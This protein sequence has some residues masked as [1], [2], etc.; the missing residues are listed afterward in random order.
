MRHI[1]KGKEPKVLTDHKKDGNTLYKGLNITDIQQ[2]LLQEQRGLCA[3]CMCRIDAIAGRT[4]NMQVE[5]VKCRTNY[6]DDELEYVNMLG[7]CFGGEKNNMMQPHCDKSKDKGEVHYE[8]R[9][10][11]PLNI[12]VESM[13]TFL[14][15]GTVV[16]VNNDKDVIMDIKALN[17]NEMYTRI[18]R[19]KISQSIKE[20]YKIVCKSENKAKVIQFLEK[21]LIKWTSCNKNG[22][23]PEY[24]IV[25]IKFL[26][27]KLAHLNK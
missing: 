3:Y 5:H 10:L 2:Q 17:L 16:A 11:D 25:A 23:L 22:F 14:P 20:E 8:L 15:T 7:V 27:K 21:N 6:P 24:N 1:K 13:L 9:K 19:E 12:A 4:P 18:N 26:K